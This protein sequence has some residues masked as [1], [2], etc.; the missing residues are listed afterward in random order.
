MDHSENWPIQFDLKPTENGG[1]NWVCVIE[2]RWQCPCIC[3]YS[4]KPLLITLSCRECSSSRKE[5]I[6]CLPCTV[7]RAKYWI[8]IDGELKCRKEMLY[9]RVVAF[10]DEALYVTRVDTRVM[11]LVRW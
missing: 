3:S 2:V 10:S 6:L 1:N 11:V 4:T 8:V 9:G 5:T 7:D